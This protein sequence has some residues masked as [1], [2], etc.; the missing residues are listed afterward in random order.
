MLYSVIYLLSMP[1]IAAAFTS[2]ARV[3]EMV[4]GLTWLM[5]ILQPVNTLAFVFDGVFI[6]ANDTKFLSVQ[7]AVTFLG[8]FVPALFLL[9]RVADMKLSGLWIA[10]AAF[11]TARAVVLMWRYRQPAWLEARVKQAASP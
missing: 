2:D 10:M 11:S 7:I 1:W 3:I 4:I 9:I 8:I 5:A 6:G